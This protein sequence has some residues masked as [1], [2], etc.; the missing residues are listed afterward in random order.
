MYIKK[1]GDTVLEQSAVK[2]SILTQHSEP[3]QISF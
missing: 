1:D 2:Q 3:L